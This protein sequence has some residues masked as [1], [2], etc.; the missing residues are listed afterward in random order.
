MFEQVKDSKRLLGALK[1]VAHTSTIF[2]ISCP[3][4]YY[5]YRRGPSLN[6]FHEETY[7][8]YD[9]H[10][11]TESVLGDGDWYLGSPLAGFG[12]FGI[13]GN[14]TN[15]MSFSEAMEKALRCRALSVAPNRQQNLTPNNS[16]FY[17]SVRP[18]GDGPEDSMVSF[19]AGSDYRL[20]DVATASR[21]V[22]LGHKRR[23][24]FV[25][26]RPGW[27]YDNIADNIAR[28]ISDR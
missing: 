1:T 2:I 3:N 9:F 24:A 8:F 19:A 21:D 23:L 27:A 5:Y 12:C 25:I 4:D 15:S 13:S 26:D 14:S 18:K 11:I 10:S 20:P 7:S 22:R 17:I 28:R 16:L 6:P